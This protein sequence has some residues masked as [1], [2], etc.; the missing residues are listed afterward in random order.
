MFYVLDN[1]M[2]SVNVIN[3]YIQT[4]RFAWKPRPCEHLFIIIMTSHE[5]NTTRICLSRGHILKNAIGNQRLITWFGKSCRIFEL[6]WHLNWAM[7]NSLQQPLFKYNIALTPH[8]HKSWKS[9]PLRIVNPTNMQWVATIFNVFED[10]PGAH[11]GYFQYY[12]TDNGLKSTLTS[13]TMP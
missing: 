10:Y 3:V 9:F 12:S 2:R 6:G 8:C 4:C 1:Y 11:L 5:D 7:P 13:I